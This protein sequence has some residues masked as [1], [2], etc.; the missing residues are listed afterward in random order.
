VSARPKPTCVTHRALAGWRCTVCNALLCPDCAATRVVYPTEVTVCGLCGELVEPLQASR[1]DADGL[2]RQAGQALLYP[3]HGL[4]L[5]GW[6]ALVV[7]L[8]VGVWVTSLGL[9]FA[10][11]LVLASLFGVARSAGRG[12]GQLELMNFTTVSADV[13]WP[14]VRFAT[15]TAP[16]WLC[17]AFA[18]RNHSLVLA[19]VGAGLALLWCPTAFLGAAAGTPLTT[20][21]NPLAV[22]GTIARIGSDVPRLG[23]VLLALLALSLVTGGLGA[24]VF[25][26]PV[27]ILSTVLAC[28]AWLYTPFVAARV[29]GL[30]LLLHP[31]PFGWHD[32]ARPVMLETPRGVPPPTAEQ[33]RAVVAPLELP[34]APAPAAPTGREALVARFGGAPEDEPPEPTA[35]PARAAAMAELEL[36]PLSSHVR[37]LITDAMEHQDTAGA[38]EAFVA[39]GEA[40]VADLD[41]AQLLWLGRGAVTAGDVSTAERALGLAAE[42]STGEPA[43]TAMVLRAR[44]LG[45]RLGRA[46]EATALMQRVVAEF[47]G[48]KPAA[49]AQKWLATPRGEPAAGG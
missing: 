29:S 35:L 46:D 25:V 44:L 47:S 4:G 34:D 7:T 22:L 13:L 27:P 5:V 8:S 26:Q 16:A 43:A 41:G 14:F 33:R 9:L 28:A 1:A 42:R 2:F 11:G 15:A 19:W 39:A 40:D 17:L 30:V 12:D 37:A 6:L 18:A 23:L 48:S 21:A 45:E 10:L 24:W 32:G 36:K 49:F 20:L 3:F 31:E 38:L